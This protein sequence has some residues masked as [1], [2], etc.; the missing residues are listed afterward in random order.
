MGSTIMLEVGVVCCRQREILAL[1]LLSGAIDRQG[2]CSVESISCLT[3][4]EPEGLSLG[5]DP[6]KTLSTNS[7]SKELLRAFLSPSAHSSTFNVTRE[8][9]GIVLAPKQCLSAVCNT[10]GSRSHRWREL[11]GGYTGTEPTAMKEILFFAMP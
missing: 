11:N 1:V 2:Y 10:S 5:D 4:D 6:L 3:V 7:F 8:S 9:L